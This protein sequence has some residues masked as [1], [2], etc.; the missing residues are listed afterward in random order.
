MAAVPCGRLWRVTSL[1]VPPGR[2]ALAHLVAP[3]PGIGL[4]I[5]RGYHKLGERNRRRREQGAH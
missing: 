5:L 1:A 2:E 4:K 3:F